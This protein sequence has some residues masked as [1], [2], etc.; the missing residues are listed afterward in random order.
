[1]SNGTV[2]AFL[3]SPRKNG[4]TAAMLAETLAGAKSAGMLVK[5]YWLNDPGVRGCQAC[6]WCR[7]QYGCA[8]KDYLAPMY[9]EIAEASAVVFASPCYFFQISAQAKAW[10]DRSFPMIAGEG[11][12]FEPRQPGKK[13][14]ALY[15]QGHP[16]AALAGP[17]IDGMGKVF[18]M[19][20]WTVTA[21][22]LA[23]GM[24]MKGTPSF[25]DLL[26]QARE[27]GV[28]LAGGKG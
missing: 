21:T 25:N 13:V 2:V 16:D 12:T 26:R 18:A 7:K 15:T 28:A 4:R 6:D 14:V 5:E 22:L 17:M 23:A 3:G 10:L 27:A 1:M 9:G 20:G 11:G 19:Y 24:D 8:T